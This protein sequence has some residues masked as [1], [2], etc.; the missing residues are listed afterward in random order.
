[1][2]TKSYTHRG[3]PASKLVTIEEQRQKVVVVLM[4]FNGNLVRS[5]TRIPFETL[6]ARRWSHRAYF[7]GFQ[8]A[9]V[10]FI[11][12]SSY[13]FCC[14]VFDVKQLLKVKFV[15]YYVVTKRGLMNEFI[16]F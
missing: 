13:R 4:N 12:E 10:P 9:A 7:G 16:A 3:H 6:F 11:A 5:I 15:V 1:M 8:I 2:P 14:F